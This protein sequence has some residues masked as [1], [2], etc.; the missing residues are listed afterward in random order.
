MSGA[1]DFVLGVFMVGNRGGYGHLSLRLWRATAGVCLS[2]SSLRVISPTC[3]FCAGQS[4]P[5]CRVPAARL[6]HG[7]ICR[8]NRLQRRLGGECCPSTPRPL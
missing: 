5:S 8:C 2:S 3:L 4:A 6:R 1:R 7:V